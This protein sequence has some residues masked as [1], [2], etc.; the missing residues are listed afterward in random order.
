MLIVRQA[1]D[2]RPF[3]A[4]L[5]NFPPGTPLPE[6]QNTKKLHGAKNNCTCTAGAN[7]EPKDVKTTITKN[8]AAISEEPVTKEKWVAKAEYCA[9]LH[10]TTQRGGQT[11]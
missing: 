10:S 6:Q 2:L 5:Q 3:E 8:S 4:V 11:T 1:W 7:S 9:C